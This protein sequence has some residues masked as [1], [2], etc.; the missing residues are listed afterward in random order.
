MN[1]TSPRLSA[2]DRRLQVFERATETVLSAK[3]EIV[4]ALIYYSITIFFRTLISQCAILVKLLY[5]WIFERQYRNHTSL[6]G[7]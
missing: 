1:F 4:T 6:K 5:V 7:V 3:Q 2:N